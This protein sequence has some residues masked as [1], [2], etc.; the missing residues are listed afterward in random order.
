MGQKVLL[1]F[2]I[3]FA[4]FTFALAA[5][6]RTVMV[7]ECSQYCDFSTVDVM[8]HLAAIKQA[9]FIKHVSYEHLNLAGHDT[10]FWR[11]NS[12]TDIR[13][14]LKSMGRS[15]YPMFS[16]YPHED[17]DNLPNIREMINDKAKYMEY[18]HTISDYLVQIGVTGLNIDIEP[19]GS[20]TDDNAPY[21]AFLKD[22]T[23]VFHAKGLIVQVDVANW[24]AITRDFKA[25]A[26][27]GVDR[28]ITMDSY[29]GS[30]SGFKKGIERLLSQ[31]PVEKAVVGMANVNFNNN[32]PFTQQELSDR[33]SYLLE[34]GVQHV[35]VWDMPLTSDYLHM[36]GNFVYA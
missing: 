31:V 1:T 36:L 15:T 26:D 35:A 23:E 33:L 19:V 6:E 5:A 11:V 3:M 13:S 21:V 25:I 16:I 9:E 28:I 17:L 2:F 7:W 4:T 32:K 8:Q 34:R 10:N 20:S 29:A 12:N 22:L 30:F 24:C 27:A 14:E 18:V